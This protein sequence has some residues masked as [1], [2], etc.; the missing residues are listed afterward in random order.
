M[1]GANESAESDDISNPRYI[2]I[3]DIDDNNQLRKDTYKSLPLE[4]AKEY[5]LSPGDILFARSGAT[6]GKTYLYP[7]G[8]D[9]CF[10][11]YLI[12]ARLNSS[13]LPEYAMFY[14]LSSCYENWKNSIYIQATIQNIGADKY[15]TMPIT[16]PSINEQQEI[17]NYLKDKTAQITGVI[18][19]LEKQV[20]DLIYYKTSIIS[21]AVTG[22]IDLRNW[23]P[24]K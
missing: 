9:A 11:G 17:V 2:R 8:F 14:T 12:R 21:E 16:V 22:K 5:M 13:M 20:E 1:Y 6:V 3:T 7:G 19:E 18:I 4:K 15:S 24:E 10:A 23:S